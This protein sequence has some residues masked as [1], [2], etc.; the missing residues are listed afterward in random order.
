M[1]SSTPGPSLNP[2]AQ[3]DPNTPM[4]GP[5]GNGVPYVVGQNSVLLSNVRPGAVYPTPDRTSTAY[6][7]GIRLPNGSYTRLLRAD[8]F[9][10]ANIPATQ[11]PDGLIIL[12]PT[13]QQA[14]G[15]MTPERLVPF[16]VS[17][18]H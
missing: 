15:P 17:R 9:P 2:S 3:Y 5:P 16:D 18:L 10:T 6:A 4:M 14:P 8:E 11:G 1:T 13:T 12:P 7:Y